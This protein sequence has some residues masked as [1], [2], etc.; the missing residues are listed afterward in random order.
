MAA[1]PRCAALAALAL[2]AACAH[3]P[4]REEAPKTREAPAAREAPASVVGEAS[5]YGR[6]FQGR[7]TASG[8][9]YDMSQL[10]CAHPTAPFGTRLRVT[11]LE[12]GRS[13]VVTVNDRGPFTRGRVVDVSL[14]AARA[15]GMVER[16]VARVRVER[17]G[18]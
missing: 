18:D 7:R 17:L 1:L 10:T 4:P 14:A 12:T 15:L 16:G 2:S 9:R 3:A 5:F 13:V 6:R 8:E 11:D